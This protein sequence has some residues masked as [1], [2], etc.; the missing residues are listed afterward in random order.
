MY[1]SCDREVLPVKAPQHFLALRLVGLVSKKYSL[2]RHG[3]RA[4]M[5]PERRRCLLE[6]FFSLLP[7][8]GPLVGGEHQ[9][10]AGGLSEAYASHLWPVTICKDEIGVNQRELRRRAAIARAS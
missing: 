5:F 8:A 10:D 3:H 1:K 6:C 4:G 9:S 2:G 7:K